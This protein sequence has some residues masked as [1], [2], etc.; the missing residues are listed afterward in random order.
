MLEEHSKEAAGYEV[1]IWLAADGNG[2]LF[3][4]EY[5]RVNEH[6]V[7]AQVMAAYNEAGQEVDGF[8]TRPGK[9]R[10]AKRTPK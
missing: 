6:E 1:G 2:E 5:V 4:D 8:F 7:T 9:E 3:V 10:S